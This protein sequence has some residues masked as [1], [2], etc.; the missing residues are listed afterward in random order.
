MSWADKLARGS[1]GALALLHAQAH[2]FSVII[3]YEKVG[4]Q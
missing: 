3:L 2:I 4:S 1:D